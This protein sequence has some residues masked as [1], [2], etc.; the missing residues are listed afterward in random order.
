L[1]RVAEF[2][3]YYEYHGRNVPIL[4]AGHVGDI[5]YRPELD[6]LSDLQGPCASGDNRE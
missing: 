3:P 2:I 5:G 4:M 6:P 1:E